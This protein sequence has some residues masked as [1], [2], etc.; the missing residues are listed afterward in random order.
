M[1]SS[2]SSSILFNSSIKP[3]TSLS[4]DIV[5]KAQ[6]GLAVRLESKL[7][8]SILVK[9]ALNSAFDLIIYANPT[10]TYLLVMSNP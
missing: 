8:S 9:S 3:V 5:I 1:A 7:A 4:S 10:G 2:E 6:A